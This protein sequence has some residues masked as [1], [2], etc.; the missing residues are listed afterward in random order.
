MKRSIR[1]AIVGFSILGGVVGFAGSLLWLQGVNLGSKNW[2]VSVSFNDASGLAERSRV[3]YRGI[4]IGSVGKI[5]VKPKTVLATLEIN[6][7]ELRLPKPVYAKVVTSSLLGGDVQVALVS[8]GQK[9]ILKG[10][11]PSSKECIS[12]EILCNGDRIKGKALMSISTLT[13]EFERIL[14]KADDQDFVDN[15]VES[16]K[17]FDRT[18]KNLDELVIK[19]KK[20]V[21]RAEPIIENLSAASNHLKNILSAIDN[22]ETLRDIQRTA[23]STRSITQKVDK[24]GSSFEKMLEDKELMDALRDVTI[25]LG[26]LFNELYPRQ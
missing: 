18:Q 24:M 21:S 4:L 14:R 9:S 11:L 1:D 3:T 8:K 26:E 19:A 25:G 22:P 10:P 12:S 13:E 17:Q 23:S 15:L 16:T 6:N 2:Q 7:P 20:E 5:H